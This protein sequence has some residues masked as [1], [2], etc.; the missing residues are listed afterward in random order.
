MAGKRFGGGHERITSARTGRRG[1][2]VCGEIW[3]LRAV[4]WDNVSAETAY[5][6]KMM[7]EKEGYMIGR[8]FSVESV[9]FIDDD[10]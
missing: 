9:H 4:T 2:I 6:Q 7:G 10:A 8:N 5:S 1:W 3:V